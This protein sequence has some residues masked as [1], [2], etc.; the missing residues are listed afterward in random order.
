MQKNGEQTLDGRTDKHTNRMKQARKK[1][2]K[3]YER[4]E[5]K[6]IRMNLINVKPG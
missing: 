1:G 3:I 4:F 6:R 5:C 2:R